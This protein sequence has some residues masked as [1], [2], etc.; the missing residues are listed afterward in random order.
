MSI[1]L[2]SFILKDGTINLMKDLLQKTKQDR[3]EHGFDLCSNIESKEFPKELI[4]RNICVGDA[5][6]VE[7]KGECEKGEVLE[8][9]YHT[10]RPALSARPSLHD[11]VI[12][13]TYGTECLG[14]ARD[15]SIKCY[16]K[17]QIPAKE[18]SIIMTRSLQL[19]NKFENKNLTEKEF[20]EFMR[21]EDIIREKYFR[22]FDVK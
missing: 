14:A 6:E 10:H 19:I 16:V 5:C 15:D 9:G 1:K 18:E 3:L 8:G 17:K 11:L 21:L 20:E 22:I 13:L 4:P 12:G 2:N 7:M